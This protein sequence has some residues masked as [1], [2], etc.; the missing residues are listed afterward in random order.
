[1]IIISSSQ[2][3][4]KVIYS[5]EKEIIKTIVGRSS[6][7]KIVTEINNIIKGIEI[8]LSK[9]NKF[10]IDIGPGSFTG[11][12]IG[13]AVMQ[14]LLFGRENYE[15]KKFYSSDVLSYDY[16]DKKIAIINR[17]RED[18]A[19]ITLYDKGKR[20]NDPKMVF[21]EQLKTVLNNRILIGEQSEHFIKKYNL[22]NKILIPEIKIDNYIYA[23]K[24]GQNIEPSKLEPLYIQKPI[25]VEN[26]EKQ[27][28]KIIEDI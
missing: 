10:G 6:G 7:S 24:K 20:I 17:A 28:N 12:R 26:Y 5:G 2:R 1:M 15:L 11:I 14:G 21:G 27:N 13:I 19:Y 22:K 18:A 8:D 9:I 25:A 3:E 4:V 16:K 23:F